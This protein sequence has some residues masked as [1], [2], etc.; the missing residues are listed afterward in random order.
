MSNKTALVSVLLG[1]LVVG[2]APALA[3]EQTAVEKLC[4]GYARK[5]A[6]LER[7]M[8]IGTKAW[9]RPRLQQQLDKVKADRASFCPAAASAPAPA[10]PA[11]A[12]KP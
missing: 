10:A 7:R 8:K 9:E 3:G 4:D 12:T 1:L 2:S 11:P 5:Q 6:M